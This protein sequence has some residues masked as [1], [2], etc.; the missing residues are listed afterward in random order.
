MKSAQDGLNAK[1]S[2]L[3]HIIASKR[4]I[5]SQGAVDDIEKVRAEWARP[6]GVVVTNRPVNEGV[7]LD[8]QSFDFAGWKSS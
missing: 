1:Q 8:D 6:D 4:L 5:L 2:K 3:Q 7:K